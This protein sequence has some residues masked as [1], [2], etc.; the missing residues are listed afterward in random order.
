MK[1]TEI[2]EDIDN[3]NTNRLEDLCVKQLQNHETA[4]LLSTEW[5]D[6]A[7]DQDMIDQAVEN[8]KHFFTAIGITEQLDATVNIFGRVFPWFQIKV[9]WS[10][11]ICPLPHDNASP[12]NNRCGEGGTHWDLPSEPDEETRLAIEAHNQLDIALYN[13]AVAHFELQKRAIFGD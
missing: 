3:G 4:N 5:P 1:L 2:Y 9:E 8:M 10:N 11:T 12:R 13:A 7:K 6:D